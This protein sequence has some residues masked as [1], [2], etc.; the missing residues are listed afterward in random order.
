MKSASLHILC[1]FVCVV[2]SIR[3][4]LAQGCG[5]AM[6][7]NFSSY[8]TKT[9]DGTCIYTSVLVDGSASCTPTPSC[10]CGSATHTP[11]AYNVIGSVGGWGSGPGQCVNCYLSYQNNQSI[12]AQDG[13][14]FA[15]QGTG[16]V[17]CS[18]AGIFFSQGFPT[19]YISIAHTKAKTTSDDH[20]GHC[21][22]VSIC[23]N[24][25]TPRCPISIVNE[26]G[27]DPCQPAYNC[28]SLAWR[29]TKSAPY[30]CSLNGCL[31][32]PD[33]TPSNSCTPK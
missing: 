30:E 12:A 3:S 23:S 33:V 25:S 5:V 24:T 28:T 15:F 10:P 13:V 27:G 20:R 7:K 4:G 17:V 2:G 16:E 6:T 1:S 31:P 11:K 21:Q 19:G 26:F 8:E 9:T 18:L 14:E 22:T 29:L 32:T